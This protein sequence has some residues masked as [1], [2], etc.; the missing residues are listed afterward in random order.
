LCKSE[1][2]L[3]IERESTRATKSAGLQFT[4]ATVKDLSMDVKRIEGRAGL[5][6]VRGSRAVLHLDGEA[7][8]DVIVKGWD[9]SWGY[10]TFLP[11]ERFSEYAPLYGLWSLLMHA[12]DEDEKL[13]D[14][15]SEELLQAEA[16]I[17]AI[18]TRLY[19]PKNQQWAD[20]AELNIDGEM[21]E[22]KE[23]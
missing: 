9:G 12:D 14:A 2:F 18:R 22:W 5:A 20:V 8:G 3:W 1:P 6:T 10:G 21:L 15:A 19:F 16:Q 7:V 17:D 23:Y 13:S 11:S 4:S